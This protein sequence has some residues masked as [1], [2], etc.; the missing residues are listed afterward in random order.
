VNFQ[1]PRPPVKAASSWENKFRKA[2]FAREKAARTAAFECFVRPRIASA[3]SKCTKF[4]GMRG[5][6]RMQ[7][8]QPL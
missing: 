5:M 2:L 8:P 4:S 3:Y 7:E 1:E 6:L